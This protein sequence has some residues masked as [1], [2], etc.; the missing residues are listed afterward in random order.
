M[1]HNNANQPTA[2]VAA[3][4]FASADLRRYAAQG[5]LVVKT[6]SAP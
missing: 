4:P 5:F 2:P 1:K 6:G 3:A